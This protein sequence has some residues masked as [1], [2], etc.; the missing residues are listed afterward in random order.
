MYNSYFGANYFLSRLC[1]GEHGIKGGR[2]NRTFLSRLCG[3]ELARPSKAHDWD[4]LS[5]LCG[6]EH[7]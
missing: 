1:G 3:G 2:L 5:R 6:G 7:N 4:F